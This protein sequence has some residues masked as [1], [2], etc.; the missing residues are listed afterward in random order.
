MIMQ[1][2]D[3]GE[4]KT[5]TYDPKVMTE[6]GEMV[7]VDQLVSSTPGFTAQMTGRLTKKRYKYAT[8]FVNQASK[9]C[10]VYM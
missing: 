6:P 1:Q 9:L 10:Y 5:L 8:V 2:K 7:S 3:Y 4:E